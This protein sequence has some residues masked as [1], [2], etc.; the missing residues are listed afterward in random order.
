MCD[1]AKR[2]ALKMKGGLEVTNCDIKI[3]VGE[4]FLPEKVSTRD[5]FIAIRIHAT[6]SNVS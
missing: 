2:C 4:S 3:L 5:G 6:R 1:M